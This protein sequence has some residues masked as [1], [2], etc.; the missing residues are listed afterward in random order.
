MKQKEIKSIIENIGSVISLSAIS[1]MYF[2][3]DKSWLYHKL[4]EDIVHGVKYALTDEELQA[5][6]EALTDIAKRITLSARELKNLKQKRERSK[7]RY[8]T[9]ANPFSHR[10]FQEWFSFIPPNATILEPFAGTCNIPKLINTLI[11]N[12]SWA[13]Y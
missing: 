3:K 2:A 10:L 11:A 4:N 12:V 7:G 13:C 9:E 8:L 6:T 1:R 5:L